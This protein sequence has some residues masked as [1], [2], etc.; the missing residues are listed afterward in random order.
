MV[1]DTGVGIEP[2]VLARVFDKPGQAERSAGH[3]RGGLGLGLGLVRGLVQL[4]GGDVE[5][6]SAGHGR[7]T[8]VTV[9]LPLAEPPAAPPEPSA[10]PPT[11]DRTYRMLLV[12][13]EA[14]TAESMQLLLELF[15]HQVRVAATGPAAV[16]AAR[17]TVPEVVLC[18]IGLPGDMD[19]YAVAQALR[20][21]PLPA[22]TRLIALTGY[23]QDEDLRRALEAGFDAHLT[24][25]VR[26]GDLQ[27]LLASLSARA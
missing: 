25:P 1:R 23:G 10:G 2:A 19:G 9:R 27:Q 6:A 13:D 22:A 11:P 26:Y 14:D 18:D 8:T 15:G 16:E 17:Q 3:G 24:K 5:V 7:G 4:H 12:E 20:R 21:E